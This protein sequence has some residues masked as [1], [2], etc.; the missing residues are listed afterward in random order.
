MIFDT[1]IAAK[2]HTGNQ[3]QHLFRF[4]RKSAFSIGIRIQIPKTLDYEVV[5]FK[6]HFIHFCTVFIKLLYK[7]AHGI[8]F[9]TSNVENSTFGQLPKAGTAANL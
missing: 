2:Y 9:K 8:N 7:I 3:T 1:I 5:L 4:N 6:D